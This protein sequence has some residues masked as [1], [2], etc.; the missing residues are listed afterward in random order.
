[1]KG[2]FDHL[3]F[4]YRLEKMLTEILQIFWTVYGKQMMS[5]SKVLQWNHR[6]KDYLE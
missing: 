5:Q 2:Y 1:V 4:C 6:F 3:K